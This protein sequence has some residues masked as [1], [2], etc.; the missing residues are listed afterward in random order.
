M[1]KYYF[2]SLV[3]ALLLVVTSCKPDELKQPVFESPQAVTIVD[4]FPFD[5]LRGVYYGDFGGTELRL[6]LDFVSEGHAIGSSIVK[7]LQR[8]ISGKVKHT[9]HTVEM[10]LAE[11]GDNKY[12]GVFSISFDRITYVPNGTW[13]P[14]DPKLKAKTFVLEKV[15]Y[16][17]DQQL[18]TTANFV[19]YFDIVS[20]SLGR[21][22]F[23]NNGLCTYTSDGNDTDYKVQKMEFTGSWSVKDGKVR[24]E[25]QENPVFSSRKSVFKIEADKTNY[26]YILRGESR[27]FEAVY[28]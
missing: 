13:K 3:F 22:E 15:I 8:N 16:D 9:E 27:V 17:D 18:M 7:G 4:S 20:D 1:M 5:T 12:D 25:W 10:E 19:R 26:V 24:I 6:V 28:N 11:P 14:N 21:I 23:E 2:F